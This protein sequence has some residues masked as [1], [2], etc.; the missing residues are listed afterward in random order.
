MVE[1]RYADLVVA[2]PRL[3]VSGMGDQA[4]PPGGDGWQI[5]H[6]LPTTNMQAGARQ[7][8]FVVNGKIS[9]RQTNGSGI[10]RGMFQVCLG[11]TGGARFPHH[12][13]SHTMLHPLP[14]DAG[15]P[16]Q[17]LCIVSSAVADEVLGASINPATTELCVWARVFWNGDA[18][19]YIASFDVADLSWLWWDLTAIPSGHWAAHQVLPSAPTVLPGAAGAFTALS[20]PIGAAGEQWLHFQHVWYEPRSYNQP[21]TQWAM[22]YTPDG[23]VPAFVGRIGSAGWGMARFPAPSLQF[24]SLLEFGQIQQGGFWL[25]THTNSTTRAAAGGWQ[26]TTGI[27]YWKRY[28]HVAVRVDTLTD[29]RSRAEPG[30]LAVGAPAIGEAWRDTAI[31]VERPAAG[32]LVEPIVLVHGV[33]RE[34]NG[35]FGGHALRVFEDVAGPWFGET[36]AP[37]V[38]ASRGEGASSIA[39]GRRVF[40]T[41]SPSIQWKAG[42]AGSTGVPPV[43]QVLRDFQFVAFHPVRDPENITTPPGSLPAPI[44]LVPG[45]QAPGVGS[46]PSPP[47]QPSSARPQRARHERPSIKGATGYR[48]SWPLGARPLAE[49]SLQ[50]GPMPLAEGQAVW[51]FLRANLAW[52]YVPPRSAAVAAMSTSQPEMAAVD[53]RNVTVSV[54]VAILTFTGP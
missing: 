35:S 18:P 23:T 6:V 53:H 10:L 32:T 5:V 36:S 51:D 22:G 8:A 25:H 7:Y 27:T 3:T 2:P 14:A 16:F 11:T 29:L 30:P 44:V 12:R 47:S 46:L 20:S 39:V 1:I 48:R 15:I 19:T 45:R 26:P 21:A 52:A 24:A 34:A 37:Q 40:Q 13:A 50:W 31:P 33:M 9:N 54:D 49:L 43:P 17:F 4:G 42:L 41:T 38:E 28:N